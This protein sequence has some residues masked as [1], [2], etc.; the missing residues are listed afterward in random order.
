MLNA[1]LGENVSTWI[2]FGF[3]ARDRHAHNLFNG[4][5]NGDKSLTLSG[6]DTRWT[7]RGRLP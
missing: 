4:E 1:P 5:D 7:A 2:N 6:Q 3:S